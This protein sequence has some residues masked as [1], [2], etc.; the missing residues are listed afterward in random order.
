MSLRQS[1]I[2][3]LL[4]KGYTNQGII[5]RE[6]NVSE[7]TVSRDIKF[8]EKQ[9]QINLQNHIKRRIPLEME[10]C[11][12]GLKIVLRKA[13]EVFDN[14]T[15]SSEKLQ[16]LQLILTT[17]DKL[18]EL[19]LDENYAN[20][21]VDMLQ[22]R[23]RRME[24]RLELRKEEIIQRAKEAEVTEYQRQRILTVWPSSK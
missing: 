19:L 7:A 17:Y 13:Y 14:S 3:E 21:S 11:Y 16:A 2:A 22:N 23:E 6:L 5:A 15:R 8:L 12:T 9:A 20:E 1:R 18:Q 4:A 24:E 10:H